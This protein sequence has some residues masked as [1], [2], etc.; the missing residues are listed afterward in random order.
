MLRC[1]PLGTTQS[2][3][4]G[5]AVSMSTAMITGKNG[6]RSPCAINAGAVMVDRVEVT[7]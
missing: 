6:L 4:V 5:T 7:E 3:A 2:A 1:P